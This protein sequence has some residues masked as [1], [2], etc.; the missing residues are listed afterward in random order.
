MM[1]VSSP[2]AIPGEKYTDSVDLAK[3]NSGTLESRK[4]KK[5]YYPE[6]GEKTA[7]G[8]EDTWKKIGKISL[9]IIGII[10]LPVGV[11]ILLLVAA[12]YI[13]TRKNPDQ[14][15][16]SPVATQPHGLGSYYQTNVRLTQ[17]T[18]ESLKWKKK[19]IESAQESIELSGN[20]GGGSYFR[21]TM[22]L[23]EER[24]KLREELK[25]HLMFSTDLLEK[26]DLEELK[27]LKGLFGERFQYL[28]TDRTIRFNL[29]ISCEENHVKLLVVDGKYFVGGGT[30]I[31]PQLAREEYNKAE[32]R[33]K[34]AAAASV[35]DETA[36]DMDIVCE[37][38]ELAQ[39]CRKQFFNL[40]NIYEKQTGDKNSPN[41]LFALTGNSG[42]CQ[43]FTEEP[44]LLEN[45]RIKF[46][47]SGPE[48]RGASA[49]TAQYVKRIQKTK[50]D[51]HLAN[52][53]L[54]PCPDIRQALDKARSEGKK[55]VM[56]SNGLPGNPIAG[57]LP[58]VFLNRGNYVHAD[59]VYEFQVP[60]QNF[61]KKVGTFGDSHMIIG[62]YNLG[63]KSA[64]DDH[65]VVWVIK[66][67]R[68]TER[69]Q[70]QIE[71]D[72]TRSKEIS[73][74]TIERWSLVNHMLSRTTAIFMETFL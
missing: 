67:K 11:G 52:W 16:P 6:F 54:N 13:D 38:K 74:V 15:S 47:V 27:R 22:K 62:S 35:L 41:R 55:V 65:E 73:R 1:T 12:H 37:G 9:I 57:R 28:V 53:M 60:K 40:Y 70:K 19:L 56:L 23:I 29:P 2:P 17:T 66:D 59:K 44:G 14:K 50:G 69:C 58:L 3:K 64:N 33:E 51:I 43:A 39:V 25:T 36:R 5:I 8:E 42:T 30:G 32:D 48:H 49:I 26:S 34:P 7:V 68:V 63:K 71:F 46:V 24:M 10:T 45:V 20:Y 72:T 4:V 31:H 61:H 18:D 21:E